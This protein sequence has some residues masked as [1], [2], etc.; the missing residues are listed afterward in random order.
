MQ[1]LT[2]AIVLL[3]VYIIAWVAMIILT[4]VTRGF[5]ILLFGPVFL[6]LGIFA[7]YVIIKG[8]IESNNGNVF[9]PPFTST[10]ARQWF[11]V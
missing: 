9:E 1:A 3:I 2:F 11:K 10:F 4:I 7:L 8:A 6:A 5:G